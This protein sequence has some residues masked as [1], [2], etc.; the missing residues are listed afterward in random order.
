MIRGPSTQVISALLGGVGIMLLISYV[1]NQPRQLGGQ[2]N[3]ESL[4][5]TFA[6]Q[7]NQAA[8]DMSIVRPDVTPK[9][10]QGLAPEQASRTLF[11]GAQSAVPAF[12]KDRLEAKPGEVVSLTFRNDSPD[13]QH[14]FMLVQ[15]G[16]EQTVAIAAEQAGP[17]Q[18]FTPNLPDL[19]IA[20]TRLLDPGQSQTILFRAPG[21]PGS[22]P[23]ICAFPGHWTQMHGVLEVR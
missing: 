8:P 17:N 2:V 14:M 11:I 5:G 9:A 1:A 3:P 22:Y 21:R 7:R 6:V 4:P 13:H 16:S 19:I 20:T 18:S 12:D 10:Q 23:F 15:P